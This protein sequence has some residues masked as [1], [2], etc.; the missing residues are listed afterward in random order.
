MDELTSVYIQES[1]EQLAEMEAGLRDRGLDAD[2]GQQIL[3]R[4]TLGRV[5]E[6]VVDGHQRQAAPRRE[7]QGNGVDLGLPVAERTRPPGLGLVAC[8]RP[9]R[10]LFLP[11]MR[12][13]CI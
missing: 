13:D 6:D 12:A 9:Q 7:G 2:R 10:Q 11:G 5:V 1:R 3:Q 8:L 4:A